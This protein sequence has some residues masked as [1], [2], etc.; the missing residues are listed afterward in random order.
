[1]ARVGILPDRTT[2]TDSSGNFTFQAVDLPYDLV[3]M[4]NEE[5]A[6]GVVYKGL[7]AEAP[8][9]HLTT[10]FSPNSASVSGGMSGGFYDQAD[11]P[12][13]GTTGGF[14]ANQD[15]AWQVFDNFASTRFTDIDESGNFQTT[16]RW[17]NLGSVTGRVFALH[18][19][20]SSGTSPMG[21]EAYGTSSELT[22]TPSTPTSPPL[23]N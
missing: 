9:A 3:V 2:T 6:D 4:T 20:S 21:Y 11:P 1:M 8:I 19:E 17:S 16:A 22:L 7:G 18:A 12:Q 14:I 23:R 15:G 13:F 5:T 10:E